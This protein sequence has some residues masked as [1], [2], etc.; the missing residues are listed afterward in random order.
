M[1][2]TT[3]ER[4]LLS[5]LVSPSEQIS[6]TSIDFERS[7]VNKRN[8]NIALFVIIYLRSWRISNREKILSVQRRRLLFQSILDDAPDGSFALSLLVFFLRFDWKE[9]S[10]VLFL[11]LSPNTT[12]K[13]VSVGWNRRGRPWKKAKWDQWMTKLEKWRWASL[14][15]WMCFLSLQMFPARS[16]E[17]EDVSFHLVI[18]ISSTWSS[19]SSRRK[20]KKN[21]RPVR[22]FSYPHVEYRRNPSIVFVT[23]CVND[24]CF[25]LSPERERK[26]LKFDVRLMFSC[27]LLDVSSF[28][29]RW[30]RRRRLE[31]FGMRRSDPLCSPFIPQWTRRHRRRTSG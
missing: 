7:F 4:S 14:S 15:E 18:S 25:S 17:A 2:R 23:C 5:S 30:R 26:E 13:S 29:A 24:W 1:R 27:S 28:D 22:W 8:V 11:F 3:A 12:R 31:L 16:S 19:S 9:V 6:Q 10:L 20:E 21:N